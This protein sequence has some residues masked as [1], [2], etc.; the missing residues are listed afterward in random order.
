MENRNRNG[1]ENGNG[2]RRGRGKRNR[3]RNRRPQVAVRGEMMQLR[4]AKV[5][6]P[7][8]ESCVSF[9]EDGKIYPA[10]PR[11]TPRDDREYAC[12]VIFRENS[13]GKIGF[14]TPTLKYT[15]EEGV[16][17]HSGPLTAELVF[18]KRQRRNG[19][20]GQDSEQIIA[21][22]RGQAVFPDVGTQVTIG[23]PRTYLLREDG[24]TLKAMALAEERGMGKMGEI[25]DE[26]MLNRF[27]QVQLKVATNRPGV[28]LARSD[29]DVVVKTEHKSAYDLLRVSPDASERAIKRAF[30]RIEPTIRPDTVVSQFRGEVP[31]IVKKNAELYYQAVCLAKDKA[32]ELCQPKTEEQSE[33]TEVAKDTAEVAKPD[34]AAKPKAEPKSEAKAKTAAKPKAKTAAKPKAKTAAKPKAEPKSEAKAEPKSE[35]KAEPKSEAKADEPLSQVEKF[36]AKYPGYRQGLTQGQAEPK[37]KVQT[38]AEKPQP[39]RTLQDQLQ[40]TLQVDESA[41][42]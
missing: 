6:T 32:L 35:A 10:S 18:E 13:R 30:S 41:D 23:K 19:R 26:A 3:H 28:G 4:F 20:D 25:V 24:R 31:F 8:G 34:K 36:R 1:N 12:S 2:K 17:W 38:P 22:Y 21:W 11:F 29:G 15:L 16:E 14:A 42:E 33:A 7:S 37:P 9:I 5:Q 39:G 27:A 40:A